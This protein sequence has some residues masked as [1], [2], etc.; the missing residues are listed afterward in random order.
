[1]WICR[2]DALC[3]ESWELLL[4]HPR[5]YAALIAPALNHHDHTTTTQHKQQAEAGGARGGEEEE[6]DVAEEEEQGGLAAGGGKEGGRAAVSVV[7]LIRR[8]PSIAH[9]LIS[10]A[11]QT[12]RPQ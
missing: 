6:K 8:A 9:L 1:M 12:T 10:T 3:S 2:L 4:R 11:D 5:G 7:G